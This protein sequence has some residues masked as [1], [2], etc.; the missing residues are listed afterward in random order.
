MSQE[1]LKEVPVMSPD[2]SSTASSTSDGVSHNEAPENKLSK[3]STEHEYPPT[4]QVL[5][6]IAG[7]FLVLFLVALDRMIIGVAIPMHHQ[8]LQ[9]PRRRWLVWLSVSAHGLFIHAHHGQN[10]H[11]RQPKM[12]LSGFARYLRDRQRCVRRCS[13]LDSLGHRSSRCRLV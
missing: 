8:R 1:P 12:V 7:L 10:L 2:Q 6:I 9:L 4:S 13:Q 5:L 3:A 11:L